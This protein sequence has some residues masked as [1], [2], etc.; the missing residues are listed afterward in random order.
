M[1]NDHH[2]II[3]KANMQILSYMMGAQTKQM[4]QSQESFNQQKILL[5]LLL[6]RACVLQPYI[7]KEL[8]CRIDRVRH[9]SLFSSSFCARAPCIYSSCL[10][11]I[12]A[13]SFTSLTCCRPRIYT[14]EFLYTSSLY[15]QLLY[16]HMYRHSQEPVK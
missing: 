5:V 15:I 1:S 14:E 10:P 16:M 12:C 9:F 3:K 2:N 4:T 6:Y 8:A 7:Y 13:E 11:Y